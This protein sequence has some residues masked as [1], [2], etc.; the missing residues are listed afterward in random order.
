MAKL[1]R[2]M[3]KESLKTVKDSAGKSLE[4]KDNTTHIVEKD[5][6]KK[7]SIYWA[8]IRPIPLSDIELRSL[9]ISDSLKI[10]TNLKARKTDTIPLTR[11]KEKGKFIKYSIFIKR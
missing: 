7:D 3:E 4:I 2:L 6:N 1:A 9:K 10:A 5:A 11:N 8:G